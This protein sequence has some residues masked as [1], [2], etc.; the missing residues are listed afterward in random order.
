MW[1][2]QCT[3]NFYAFHFVPKKANMRTCIWFYFIFYHTF[4]CCWKSNSCKIMGKNLHLS[5]SSIFYLRIGLWNL[6]M[7][8][9]IF[10]SRCVWFV[11]SLYWIKTRLNQIF[12]IFRLISYGTTYERFCKIQFHFN[13]FDWKLFWKLKTV[14]F[15]KS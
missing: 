4:C 3:Y 13:E 8:F 12:V 11:V 2:I 9:R 6:L 7:I 5:K 1:T 10:W 14:D 15:L